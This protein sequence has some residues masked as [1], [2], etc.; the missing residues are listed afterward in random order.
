MTSV[1]KQSTA[2][3][4]ALLL[5]LSLA[6]Q[7][8]E[9]GWCWPS[10]GSLAKRCRIS[11]RSVQQNLRLLEIAGELE[12][13]PREGRS[14]RYRVTISRGE[15]SAPPKNPHPANP[16][17]GGEASFRGGVKP[18][19]PRIINDPSPKQQ[20]SVADRFDEF[21]GAY[22]KH[23]ARG[24]AVK[25]WRSAI[26]KTS[27]AEIVDAARQ[28]AFAMQGTDRKFIANPA[29]WLNGERW[30]DESETPQSD[31]HNEWRRA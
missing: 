24:A 21:Y 9:D 12:R 25:A 14:S 6:D 17:P 26:K 1:W 7:A 31:A 3:G 2:S 28:Y 20:L 29:T 18:A 23:V 22:P 16:A 5:L 11:E 4:N 30:L 13:E 10:V 27:Q 15:E 19:S 8:N